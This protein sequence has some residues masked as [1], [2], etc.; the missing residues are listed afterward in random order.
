MA[1]PQNAIYNFENWA[2]QLNKFIEEVIG[3]PAFIMCNS[4]GGVA[5]L[6]AA[7]GPGRTRPTR[8][9]KRFGPSSLDVNGI[10]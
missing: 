4:V 3:E 5:G 2:R 8:H 6:Q 1:G 9:E 7:V 10:L